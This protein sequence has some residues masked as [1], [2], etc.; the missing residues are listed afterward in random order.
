MGGIKKRLKHGLL[1][2]NSVDFLTRDW[3]LL[4]QHSKDQSWQNWEIRGSK[5]MVKGFVSRH[6][7]LL[8]RT[9]MSVIIRASIDPNKRG[10]V[11][12][13]WKDDASFI[14]YRNQTN[15]NWACNRG[16]NSNI[17]LKFRTAHVK[18]ASAFVLWFCPSLQ[19]LCMHIIYIHLYQNW[20]FTS[21]EIVFQ[22]P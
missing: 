7:C 13:V 20:P 18:H 22:L 21:F 3:V 5:T 12:L 16:F 1:T 6:F 14:F 4:A 19:S 17:V 2:W 9:V 10:K 8:L 11:Y 15:Q